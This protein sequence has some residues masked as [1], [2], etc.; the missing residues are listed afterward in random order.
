MR[1][2][3]LARLILSLAAVVLLGYGIRYDQS[4]YRWAG[5]AALAIA[6]LLRFYRPNRGLD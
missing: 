2:V 3:D 4:P 6:V 1:R 5:I